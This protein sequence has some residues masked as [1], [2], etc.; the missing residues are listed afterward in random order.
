MRGE[1]A[2]GDT[3]GMRV[4][5][6]D[7]EG[8]PKFSFEFVRREKGKIKPFGDDGSSLGMRLVVGE[9]PQFSEEPGVRGSFVSV[10]LCLGMGLRLANGVL[11]HLS[12]PACCHPHPC[13]F[14]AWPALSV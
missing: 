9:D 6:M 13:A 1:A 11:M 14:L 2:G 8:R 4:T 5:V 12:G 10:A 3:K 7:K